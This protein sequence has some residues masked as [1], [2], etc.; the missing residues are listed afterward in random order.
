VLDDF[1]LA[2]A[3]R[4]QVASLRADGLQIDLEESL[5]D[6]RLPQ[7][8]E[9]TLFRV[10]QEA[11]TNIRKH[12]EASK[13]RIV[14]DRPPNAV[15]LL[16]RDEGRGFRPNG[17]TTTNGRGEKIGL[18]G[19]RERVSLLGGRFE[20][21]SEPGRGTTI[22]AEVELPETEKDHEE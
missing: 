10:A 12:A 20:L 4:F 17:P 21:H 5:G 11:L 7:E 14:L 18:S 15:R 19:M 8:V 13:V 16:V 3:V 6:G 2:A 9:T 22:E 1:G